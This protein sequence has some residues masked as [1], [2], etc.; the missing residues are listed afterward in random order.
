MQIRK[1]KPKAM[2]KFARQNV[3]TSWTFAKKKGEVRVWVRV[4]KP[5][6][7]MSR[8]FA[9]EQVPRGYIRCDHFVGSHLSLLSSSLLLLFYYWSFEVFPTSKTAIFVV[10]K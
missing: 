1:E 5:N 6:V 4:A 3:G 7:R 10:Q 2:Y 9:K 8:A